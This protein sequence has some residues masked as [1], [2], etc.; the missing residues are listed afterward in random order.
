MLEEVNKKIFEL[1]GLIEKD[2]GLWCFV[3][4]IADNE[5]VAEGYEGHFSFF[6]G[7]GILLLIEE[8]R[9]EDMFLE[10]E[11][12]KNNQYLGRAWELLSE[13]DWLV[14]SKDD[15]MRPPSA[16]KIPLA[17]ALAYLQAK[18]VDIAPYVEDEL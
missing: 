6:T 4:R 15:A 18:G 7:D 14:I 10:F 17:I 1:L 2:N 8:A 9:K 13:K 16:N 5:I 12:T 3:E 11:H